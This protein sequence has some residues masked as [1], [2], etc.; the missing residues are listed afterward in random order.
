MRA[1]TLTLV[2]LSTTATA[3]VTEQQLIRQ[4]AAT[5]SA[6]A[7]VALSPTDK[8]ADRL[9]QLGL[10][11]G[12]AFIQGAQASPEAYKKASNEIAILW[13]W[14]T[15]GS[16]DFMLGQVYWMMVEAA[17]KNFTDPKS[18]PGLKSI[19]YNSKNCRL[20]SE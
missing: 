4:S 8:E 12:R 15:T 20:I 13:R 5:V 17:S 19:E 10:K 3:Q 2:L 11:N 6:F 16:P 18:A 9:L 7:C 14:V 1:I